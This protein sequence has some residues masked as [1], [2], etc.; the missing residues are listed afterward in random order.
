MVDVVAAAVSPEAA[1]DLQAMKKG[2]AAA[3]AELRMA[4]SGWLPEVLTN[5]ETPERRSYGYLY[6]DDDADDA[7]EGDGEDGDDDGN[8][9]AAT[10]EEPQD[11]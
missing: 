9:A 3:A 8:E 10:E 7:D 11:A 2:D 4:D 1:A 5:R 6:A